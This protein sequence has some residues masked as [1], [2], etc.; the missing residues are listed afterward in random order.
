MEYSKV[1]ETIYDEERYWIR[2]I[3][4]ERNPIFFIATDDSSKVFVYFENGQWARGSIRMALDFGYD[5][6]ALK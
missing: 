3:P 6:D 2:F 5:P 4:Y 1:L